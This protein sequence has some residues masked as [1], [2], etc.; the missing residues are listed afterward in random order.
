MIYIFHSPLVSE[1][2]WRRLA[3]AVVAMLGIVVHVG[4]ARDTGDVHPM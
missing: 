2:S 1:A 4:A 3:L